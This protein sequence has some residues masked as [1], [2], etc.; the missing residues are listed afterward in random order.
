MSRGR[1]G[2]RSLRPSPP[3][4]VRARSHFDKVVALTA[5]AHLNTCFKRFVLFL[6]HFD[7]IDRKELAPLEVRVAP[8]GVDGRESAV[9]KGCTPTGTCAH[10]QLHAPRLHACRMQ[11]LIDNLTGGA[12]AA[13]G[14][15]GEDKK[16]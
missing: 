13:A 15:S 3:F 10:Q 12:L 11:E 2:T 9:S 7:L 16:S 4:H 5:E 8:A 14:G 6:L 1:H